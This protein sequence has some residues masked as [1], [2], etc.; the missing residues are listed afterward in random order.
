MSSVQPNVCLQTRKLLR[1]TRAFRYFQE[2]VKKGDAMFVGQYLFTGTETTSV[3]LEIMIR[4]VDE[5]AA[6]E[7]ERV[8]KE[9]EVERKRDAEPEFGKQKE[10]K[11]EKHKALK[12][13]E[14]INSAAYKERE[15]DTET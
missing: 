4:E 15:R 1:S 11:E 12:E 9:P 6:Q 7:D 8:G 3:W 14:M 13:K 5:A 10:K 2:A